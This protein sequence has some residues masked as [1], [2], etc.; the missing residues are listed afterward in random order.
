MDFI[1]NMHPVS[2]AAILVLTIYFLAI[3]WF[4]LYRFLFLNDWVSKEQ[5]SLDGLLLGSK[6]VT[7]FSYLNQIISNR[8]MNKELLSLA[9]TSATKDVTKFLSFISMVAS[10]APFI[11]LFGTVVSLLDTFSAMAANSTG[12]IGVV[13]AGVSDALVATAVGIFVATFAY[14]YHQ[15]LKRKAYEVV[16]TIHMQGDTLLSREQNIAL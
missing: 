6:T 15:I 13:T 1:L 11:G 16:E 12:T 7:A 10:T 4:F 9:Q 3:N 5:T 8:T 14:S 2:L